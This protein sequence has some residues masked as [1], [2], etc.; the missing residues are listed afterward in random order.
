MGVT[1]T[2]NMLTV[3]HK[4]SSGISPA[5]PDVC[6]T[7][8]APSP[9]PIPYPNIAK[10]SDTADG[11]K[12]VKADGNP[13]ML[14]NSKYS[15]SSGDEAGTLKGVMSNQNMGSANPTMF[16]MDVKFDGK[17]VFRQFDIMLQN[18]GSK[19]I[20][21]PPGTNVQPPKVGLGLKDPDP[22][23]V[24]ETKWSET[25]LKCG[26]P[27]KIESKTENYE[28]GMPVL[29]VIHH[30]AKP[31]RIFR[32]ETGIVSGDEITIDW[33]TRNGPW[34]KDVTKLKVRAHGFGGTV[35]SS[36][37]L[38]IEIPAEVP[39]ETHGIKP[40]VKN[41]LTTKWTMGWGSGAGS[42]FTSLLNLGIVH[43]GKQIVTDPSKRW[44]N[45]FEWDVKIEKGQWKIHSKIE[46]TDH[47]ARSLGTRREMNK[48]RR[49][50]KKKKK[51]WKKIL[52]STWD[53]TLSAKTAWREH[54][55]DCKRG[56][57]CDC[58]GGCCIFPLRVKATFVTSGGHV[59]VD[60]RPGVPDPDDADPNKWWNAGTWFA[61]LSG[62]EGNPGSLVYAHEF[63]H[64]LGMWD[65]YPGGAVYP[66]FYSVPGS[67]MNNGEEIQIQHLNYH[68]EPGKSMH[69]WFLGKVNDDY[70]LIDKKAT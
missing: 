63:G 60:L 53:Q 2:V 28:D 55:V 14:K 62:R 27:V 69:D 4:S 47:I 31:R 56:K 65:E 57:D 22:M 10:S 17:N 23:K 34:R 7:P 35:E 39:K 40:N 25:K 33:L 18:G 50:F 3:A 29:H 41:G 64:N 21:T 38:E 32:M 13:V 8:A 67:L 58:R 51:E 24:K 5:F 54:R 37:E 36:N 43:I 42:F 16:S 59:K 52:E 48:W 61:Q 45:D 6:K 46:L 9:I 70:D 1:V 19:P 11:A 20:N 15:R 12:T 44:G 68:A 26:D 30:S 66:Q 49:K